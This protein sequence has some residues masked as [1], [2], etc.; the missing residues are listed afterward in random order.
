MKMKILDDLLPT[1][2]Q[3]AM[4]RDVHVGPFQTAV[5]T[6]NCGMA[7]TPREYAHRQGGPPVKEAGILTG[8][9]A[10]ELAIMAYSPSPLE[11]VI[12]MATINSLLEVNEKCCA[13][14]NA[15]DLLNEKGNGK[16]VAH[17]GHF[18]F[19]PELRQTAKELWVIEQYPQKEDFAEYQAENLIPR[20][21]VVGVTCTAFTNHTIEPLF[22]L[23]RITPKLL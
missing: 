12:G 10:L 19:V 8:K 17:E 23:E 6:H 22:M 7:S 3:K 9:N 2:H 5:V 14:L 16:K 20:A 13:N 15:Y 4:V 21:E 1:L 11:A 18:P